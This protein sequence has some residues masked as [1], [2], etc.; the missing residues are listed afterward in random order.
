MDTS[1]ARFDKTEVEAIPTAKLRDRVRDL[2]WLPASTVAWTSCAVSIPM[3][4]SCEVRR[5]NTST[6]IGIGPFVFLPLNLRIGV[7]LRT[8]LSIARLPPA[9]VSYLPPATAI[10]GNRDDQC[11]RSATSLAR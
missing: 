2:L 10:P 9:R 3:F 4:N 8:V 5:P 6:G 11:S 7:A 1:C